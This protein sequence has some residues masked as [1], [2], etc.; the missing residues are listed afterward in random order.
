MNIVKWA[1]CNTRRNEKGCRILEIKDLSKNVRKTYLNLKWFVGVIIWNKRYVWNGLK[2]NIRIS[3]VM[4]LV[5]D[6]HLLRNIQKFVCLF[7]GFRP[8]REFF[9]HM[10][11]GT[12]GDWAVRVIQRAIPIEI[13]LSSKT[14]E[15]RICCWTFFDEADII[16]YTDLGMSPPRFEHLTFDMRG[17]CSRQGNIHIC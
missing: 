9:T 12:H 17:E 5:Y 16:C 15:P 3:Y 10:E 11:V 7:M 4:S 13:R 2:I 6:I 1:Y 8:T 14:Y